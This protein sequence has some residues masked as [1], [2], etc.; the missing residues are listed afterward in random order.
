MITDADMGTELTTDDGVT[1]V[2]VAVTREAGRVYKGVASYVDGGWYRA[3]A[4][5]EV[6]EDVDED[7]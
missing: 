7:A 2:T 6:G 5:V 1:V 3:D 4:T